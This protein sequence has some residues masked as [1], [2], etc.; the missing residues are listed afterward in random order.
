MIISRPT[1]YGFDEYL[2]A[3]ESMLKFLSKRKRSRKWLLIAFVFLLALGLIGAFTPAWDGLKGATAADEKPIGEV[4]DH[5]ITL[6]ELRQALTFYGQQ[7]SAGRGT[8]SQDNIAQTYALYGQKVMDDLISQ[9]V[10]L[11]EAEKLHLAATDREVEERIKQTFAPWPGSEQYRARLLSAGTTPAQFE[12]SLRESIAEQKLRSFISAAAQVS[13]QEVEEDYRLSKTSYVVRWVDVAPTQFRDKVQVSEPELRAFFDQRK[14]DFRINVEQRR[15]RYIFVD[16]NRAGQALQ[17]SDDELRAEFN[18]ERAV[19]EVR[20]SQ[21]VLNI[22]QNETADPAVPKAATAQKTTRT[23]EEV[24]NLAADINARLRGEDGK[25]AE[26]FAALARQYS[27]DQ[28]G[29]LNGG[30]IGWV[31]KDTLKPD[32]P[33]LNVFSMAKDEISQ[34]IATQKND[35]VYIFKVTDRRLP[36]F[37]QS[38]EQL[39]KEAR[40]RKGYSRAVEI[41]GEAAQKLKESK[42][43]DAVLA[44]INS[45]HGNDL[46][47]LKETPFFAMGDSL[48]N[49]G[50]A[51]EF[52]QAVFGLQG[53]GD[54]TDR[55]S[56]NNG[57]AVAQ[58]AEKREPHDTTFEE[59]RAKVEDGYRTEKAKEI[60]A[61]RAR[62]LAGAASPEALSSLAASMGLKV[63]ERSG[64]TPGTDSQLGPLSSEA[65]LGKIHKLNK[66]EITREPIKVS[67]SDSYLVAAVTN[68]SDPDMGE[69][70]QKDKKAIYDRL[71]DTKRNTIYT[72]YM[73]AVQKRLKDEGEIEIYNEVIQSEIGTSAPGGAIPTPGGGTMPATPR[74]MPRSRTLPVSPQ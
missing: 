22:P 63:E 66:G 24:T 2:E 3:I 4:A 14:Q 53:T 74:N 68:R 45:K 6:R 42:N 55:V 35:K 60:A 38:R 61:E 11:Y 62:Q 29:K 71:L 31:N 26:D 36:T 59:V 47:S 8:I 44:E 46:A 9:K 64:Y 48:P 25:P 13:P 58:L 49:L 70:F 50:A 41:S 39:I 65:D 67:N 17:V 32:S 27:D 43:I 12:Q 19:K 1:A 54:V 51:S 21:I 23:R 15:A 34:P 72:S 20:V 33:L 16:Q 28:T 69:P 52:Q 57:F 10:K 40:V 18:P 37:E 30:D 73:A 5:K 56:V 7:V